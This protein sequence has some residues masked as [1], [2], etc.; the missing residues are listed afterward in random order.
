[1]LAAPGPGLPEND[2]GEAP[3]RVRCRRALHGAGRL[4]DPP[5]RGPG[6]P[7]AGWGREPLVRASRLSGRR[8]TPS[9]SSPSFAEPATDDASLERVLRVWVVNALEDSGV[10]G[11]RLPLPRCFLIAGSSEQS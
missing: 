5:P 2:A 11:H 6:P 10:R 8:P 7:F 4:G 3:S 9:L 1:M